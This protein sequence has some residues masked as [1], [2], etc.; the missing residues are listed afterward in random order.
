MPRVTA[1]H[2]QEVRDRIVR[3]ATRAFAEHGFHRAT[4]QDIVRESG[5]SVGAIYTYFKSKSELILAG[6]DLITDQELGE[7]RE[8][9]ASVTDY[10]QRVA[11]ALGYFFDQFEE[12]RAGRGSSVL[13]TQAWAEVDSDP[14]IREMVR[15]RRRDVVTSTALLLQEG[16]VRGELPAWLDVESV[17]HAVA[18]L[19][20]G[21]TIEAIEDGAAFRRDEAERRALAVLEL[22]FAAREAAPP[23]PIEPAAP[24]PYA[25]V[26]ASRAS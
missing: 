25:S 3:A 5:L 19:L 22:L 12:Q 8:R 24:R 6:C 13:M 4:M 18:A 10:R 20:D 14:A 9:L 1:A 23:V 15:R 2:E 7:L 26:K 17:A 11:T 16:V 21:I